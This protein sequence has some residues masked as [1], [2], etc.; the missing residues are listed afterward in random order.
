MIVLAVL[1]SIQYLNLETS[2]LLILNPIF[3]AYIS[4]RYSKLLYGVFIPIEYKT[5]VR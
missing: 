5:H 3:F 1:L 2:L 4:M